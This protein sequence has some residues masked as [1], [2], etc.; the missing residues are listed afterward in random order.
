MN[1]SIKRP[2][3]GLKI[4][5]NKKIFIG[6]IF[7]LLFAAS[8]MS[9]CLEEAEK[10]ASAAQ[11]APLAEVSVIALRSS[12]VALTTE[13]PGRTR[14]FLTAEVRP[15][16]GGIIRERLFHEGGH[17]KAGDVLYQIDPDSYQ[18]AYD[19]ALAALQKAQATLNS[20]KNKTERYQALKKGLVISEQDLDDV[21]IAYEQDKADVAAAKANVETARINLDRTLILAPISGTIGKSSLTAGALVTANQADTLTT[22]RTLDP[23]NVDVTRS[24]S[25]LL[26]LRQAIA[27]GR[28]KTSGA[29]TIDVKL[30]LEND[31]TYPLT[32][33]LKFAEANVNESTGSYSLTAEFPNPDKLLMPG[34][35]VRAIIEEGVADNSFLVPQRAVSRN[36]KGEPT[37]LFVN[38][39]GKVEQRVL[40]VQRSIGNDWLVNSGLVDGDQVI[41]EGSQKVRVGQVVKAIEVSVD[42]KTGEITQLHSD[43]TEKK[44]SAPPSGTAPEDRG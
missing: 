3:K 5:S 4:L 7:C 26:E 30:K 9:G 27:E 13:L 40:Q 22:I 33:T 16:V 23:I 39:S 37:A 34:M 1:H 35:Y 42:D 15:Q 2:D 43:N 19:S 17:V 18:A 36:T 14:A 8:T 25:E 11:P 24:S 21:K 31:A 41:V 6:L 20:D 32:G 44:P 38:K 29:D 28:I 12:T 10:E